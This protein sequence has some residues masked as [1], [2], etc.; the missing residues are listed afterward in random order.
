MTD[1]MAITVEELKKRKQ[2]GWVRD[3]VPCLEL[4]IDHGDTEKSRP[5]L[6]QCGLQKDHDFG[7]AWRGDLPGGPVVGGSIN[8][9]A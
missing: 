8:E 7:H 1:K 4:F 9:N 3:A 2:P 5:E 6:N